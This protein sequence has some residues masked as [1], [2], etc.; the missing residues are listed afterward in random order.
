[1]ESAAG[2]A[3]TEP[4]PTA[5]DIA[6]AEN[7]ADT[8]SDGRITTALTFASPREEGNRIGEEVLLAAVATGDEWRS[9]AMELE[10]ERE[11]LVRE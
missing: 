1:T 7:R 8:H 2:A 6:T 11:R 3:T 9:E 4:Q 10:R 5:S